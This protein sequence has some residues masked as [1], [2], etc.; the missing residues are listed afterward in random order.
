MTC[1]FLA[2]I[3][4][5]LQ[6]LIKMGRRPYASRHANKLQKLESM[7]PSVEAEETKPENNNHSENADSD[8]QA[9]PTLNG[10]ELQENTKTLYRKKAL[11][12]TPSS[13]RR[14]VRL[15][16]TV[17]ATDNLDI[18]RIFEEITVSDSEKE[19]EPADEEHPEL[20]PV[21]FE[22]M[23]MEKVD[24]IIQLLE[25]QKMKMD[26]L[27]SGSGAFRKALYSESSA[28]EHVTYKALYI[29]SQK[30]MDALMV[31]NSQ[32]HNRL[33]NALGKIEI[34]EKGNNVTSEMLEKHMFLCSSLTRATEAAVNMMSGAMP[35]PAENG[36][37][38]KS[39]AKRKRS[40]K[41]AI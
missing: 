41:G 30:K 11:K 16:S 21:S 13:V 26:E 2:L 3:L 8:A 5:L 36:V 29:D 24:Y 40:V 18:E 9:N 22:K 33:Q 15:Q 27:T 23:P 12:K 1:S 32:L 14:S 38:C 34:C 17:A 31:D 25:E 6:L 37:E 20:V 7:N 19:D 28:I 10:V 4:T 35:S 39:S